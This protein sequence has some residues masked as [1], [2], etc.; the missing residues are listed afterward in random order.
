[1][2]TP[3]FAIALCIVAAA[4]TLVFAATDKGDGNRMQ[5]RFQRLDQNGDGRITRDE[6]AQASSRMFARLDSDGD[7]AVTMSEISGKGGKHG[8][9]RFERVDADGDGKMTEAEFKQARLRWFERIDSNGDDAITLGE[10][11]S[12]RHSK[13]QRRNESQD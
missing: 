2:K 7:G 10:L 1:M 13:D 8:E 11:E 3:I 6:A 5:E 9:R 4:P 12:V